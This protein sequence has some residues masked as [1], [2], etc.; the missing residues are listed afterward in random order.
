MTHVEIMEIEE[1]YSCIAEWTGIFLT[2][3]HK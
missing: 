3:N 1:E 2:F